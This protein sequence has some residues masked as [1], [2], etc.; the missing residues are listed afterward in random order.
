MLTGISQCP[1][2]DFRKKK[3]LMFGVFRRKKD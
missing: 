1:V 3:T 2:D